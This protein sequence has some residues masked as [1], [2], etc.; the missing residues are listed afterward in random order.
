MSDT[1][2]ADRV[3]TGGTRRHLLESGVGETTLAFMESIGLFG[4]LLVDG[5]RY[6]QVSDFKLALSSLTNRHKD[7]RVDLRV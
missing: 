2:E 6:L 1:I 5:G 7:I 4:F 3:S